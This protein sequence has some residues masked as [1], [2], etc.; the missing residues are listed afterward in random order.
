MHKI[1]STGKVSALVSFAY[2]AL[3]MGVCVSFIILLARSSRHATL[4]RATPVDI[5]RIHL[6]QLQESPKNSAIRLNEIWQ[7]ERSEA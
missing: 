6:L 3:V 1:G 7:R 4:R 5:S 2:V